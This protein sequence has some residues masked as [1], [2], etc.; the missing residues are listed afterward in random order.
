MNQYGSWSTPR[1]RVAV[2]Q[3]RGV[4]IGQA[5]A[6]LLTQRN[7]EIYIQQNHWIFSSRSSHLHTYGGKRR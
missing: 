4:G 6:G 1:A 2:Q 7:Q 5:I 3:S